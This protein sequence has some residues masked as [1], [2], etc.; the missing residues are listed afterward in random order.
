ME[1]R[2]RVQT[3]VFYDLYNPSP[4]SS[5]LPESRETDRF[6]GMPLLVSL[7]GYGATKESMMRL[8]RKINDQNWVIASVE[9]PNG[10]VEKNPDGKTRTGFNWGAR[11]RHEEAVAVHHRILDQVLDDVQTQA[12][13]DPRRIFLLGFSQSVS[14]NYR[15]VFTHPNRIRGVIA[16]CGGLPGDRDE[17]IFHPSATDVLHIATTDDE[18]YDLDR[19]RDYPAWLKEFAPSVTFEVLEGGHALPREGRSL[20]NLWMQERLQAG[21]L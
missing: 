7:H 10:F 19:I 21:I 16:I 11:Y 13:I 4:S 20:I 6:P 2:I 15:Y 1:R 12:R 5:P 3:P 18:Y 8:C 14:F 17:Q 9:G